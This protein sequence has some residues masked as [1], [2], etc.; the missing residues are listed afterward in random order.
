M[1]DG[2]RTIS[3]AVRKPGSPFLCSK[4]FHRTFFFP[5]IDFISTFITYKSFPE[6]IASTLSQTY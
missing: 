2:N 4:G 3:L 1:E 6:L 5:F